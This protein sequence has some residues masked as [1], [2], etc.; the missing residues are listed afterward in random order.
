MGASEST[1]NNNIKREESNQGKL[2][3]T[4]GSR[5]DAREE[6]GFGVLCKS[7][8][9]VARINQQR[10]GKVKAGKRASWV[11]E[12]ANLGTK[13]WGAAWGPY[14]EERRGPVAAPQH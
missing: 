7:P 2:G 14:H 4:C 5:R 9:Q 11:A 8:K 12:S 6:D 3:V 1:Q 13:Q 10:R